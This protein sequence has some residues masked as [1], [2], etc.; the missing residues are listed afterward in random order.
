MR[1]YNYDPKTKLYLGESEATPNPLEPGEFL[2]PAHAT[3][4]KPTIEGKTIAWGGKTWVEVEDFRG[5]ILY[6][7]ETGD[8]VRVE[9]VEP[10]EELT[11]LKPPEDRPT[12]FQNGT[13]ET[14]EEAW[15]EQ[16]LLVLESALSLS[17]WMVLSDSPLTPQEKNEVLFWRAAIRAKHKPETSLEDLDLPE[18][19]N[20]RTAAIFERR[21]PQRAKPKRRRT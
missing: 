19:P 12:K 13:W 16:K 3:T 5:R 20:E 11:T 2:I 14:D 15:R 6:S 9:T 21:T 7:K 1:I 18:I 17:D 4:V 8:S 10:P